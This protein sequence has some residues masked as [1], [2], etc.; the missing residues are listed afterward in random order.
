MNATAKRVA[1]P[2]ADDIRFEL[3]LGESQAVA[4]GLLQGLAPAMNEALAKL[5]GFAIQSSVSPSGLVSTPVSA[6]PQEDSI[7]AESIRNLRRFF[8]EQAWP[9]FPEKP[10]GV[11]GSWTVE[12]PCTVMG[13]STRQIATYTIEQFVEDYGCIVKLDVETVPAID[14]APGMGDQRRLVRILE[15]TGSGQIGIVFTLAL[16]VKIEFKE[17]VRSVEILQFPDHRMMDANGSPLSEKTMQERE[18]ELEVLLQPGHATMPQEGQG[19]A[20]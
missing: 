2:G 9:V 1:Q 4:D 13:V 17:V 7:A 8:I 18:D 10:V 6:W 16:P 11:G 12:S 14:E 15:G 20:K 3:T 5:E 19:S